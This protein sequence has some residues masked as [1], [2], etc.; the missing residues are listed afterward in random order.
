MKKIHARYCVFDMDGLLLDT[1]GIYT[2]VTQQ[3]VGAFGQVFD[4]RLK[5]N[6]IGRPALDS[7]KYLVSALSLPLTATQYLQ[8][9]DALLRAR[10][11]YCQPLPGAESLI[12][13]LH[14]HAIPL[15]LATSSSQDLYALKTQQHRSWFDLFDAVI[16][17][18]HRAVVH[19]KPAADIFLAAAAAIHASPE[20]TLVFEDAPAGI[21]AAVAANMH[22]IA[23][24]DPQL[25]RARCHGAVQIIDSLTAFVPVEFGLP[26]Y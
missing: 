20:Q 11:P 12:R 24:P 10:F 7:A 6:M 15:A 13:H 2:E 17:G 1:E 5:A 26:A 23:V 25:A 3:I 22:A 9:R 4:W 21:Q 18:D 8:Q 14:R 16:T 19:G